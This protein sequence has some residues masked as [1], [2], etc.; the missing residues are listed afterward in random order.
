MIRAIFFAATCGLSAASIDNKFTEMRMQMM[1]NFK[2]KDSR[3]LADG[4][5][6]THYNDLAYDVST[7]YYAKKMNEGEEATI[8]KDETW[9][10]VISCD[11]FPDGDNLRANNL[12]HTQMRVSATN[13]NDFSIEG[14]MDGFGIM[15]DYKASPTTYRAISGGGTVVFNSLNEPYA[16]S[17]DY[18]EDHYTGSGINSALLL[19]DGH[20]ISNHGETSIVYYDKGD[21]FYEHDQCGMAGFLQFATP[22]QSI[23]YSAGSGSNIDLLEAGFK[24]ARKNGLNHVNTLQSGSS[25]S[26]TSES[27]SDLL[28]IVAGAA[29]GGIVT[30]FLSLKFAGFSMRKASHSAVSMDESSVRSSNNLP[31]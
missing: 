23:D 8:Y 20:F 1:Q 3:L 10:I 12:L 25:S 16:Y 26:S 9:E 27:P 4:Q 28:M 19:S 18:G 17:N 13:N 6:V 7:I 21:D 2:G 15:N 24:Q 14:F 22:M 11:R 29:I 31:P 5:V 30:V